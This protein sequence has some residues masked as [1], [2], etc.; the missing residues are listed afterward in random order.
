MMKRALGWML[1]LTVALGV[2]SMTGCS[3]STSTSIPVNPLPVSI[4]TI[5]LPGGSTGSAYSSAI[6]AN[7]GTAPYTF[8]LTSGS[9]PAGLTLSGTGVVMGTP[10]ATG[11]STFVATVT[12]ATGA[13]AS[14]TLSLTIA[15]GS[16]TPVAIV[17]NSLPGGTVGTAYS[18]TVIAANG[19]SPYSF[20][21]TT[22]S[23]P[24]GLTL[25]AG[26]AIT[27]SP[28]TAGS[29]TFTVTVTDAGSKTAS[30]NYTVVV[31]AVGVPVSITTTS[32]VGG[33]VGTAYS[34]SVVA[35]N[36]TSPY[37][38]AVTTGAL[39]AGLSLATSGAITG[40][41]T[42]AGTANFT[43]TVTDAGTKTAIA[44]LSIAIAAAVTPVSISTLT[45]PAGTVG[46]AYSAAI[47]AAN[48]TTPYSFAVTSGALPAGLSL[49]GGTISGSPTTAATS[50]FSVTV[51]DH[52]GGT[53]TQSYSVTI[54][55]AGAPPV[56]TTTTLPG[57]TMGTPYDAIVVASGGTAPYKFSVTS[58][59]LPAG[60][61]L[62]ASGGL[63]GTPTVTGPTTFTISVTDTNGKTAGAN[64]SV[65]IGAAGVGL[66]I[67]PTSLPA[68]T[69]GT[70]YTASLTA[71][72]GSTPYTFSMTGGQLPAGMT[73][74][75]GG[76]L[77]GMPIAAATSYFTVTVVD[78][79]SHVASQNYSVTMNY[80][81]P[82][83]VSITTAILPNAL[84][85]TTYTT[86]VVAT[87]GTAPYTMK[88]IGGALPSG[89]TLASN[90][91]ITGVVTKAATDYFTVQATDSSVP[92][93]TA[94][95]NLSIVSA[96]Y[97]AQVIV[98]PAHVLATVPQGF[99]GLHTS[100]Y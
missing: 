20:A 37:S 32:L 23:L 43:V 18:A 36:G 81:G 21:V 26:G 75:S 27:G 92:A 16:V 98:D 88:V 53:A 58:G 95:A 78:S 17:T 59:T 3:P 69:E 82:P 93:Q 31:G 54:A 56:I 48:G 6:L 42:A 99:F 71:A 87:G 34:A 86:H 67:T 12:D 41:P 8:A 60:V 83:T 70:F 13:K 30:A 10:T 2:L 52:N 1:A 24:A 4:G 77:S 96:S 64:Y 47:V 39:P 51:T 50:T 80:G 45:L 44:N 25:A 22:G 76:V 5:S 100:V 40:T 90:G 85:S 91:T 66:T 35:A 19:T 68:G 61:T 38:F 94:Q 11:T 84:I 7:N 57:G 55:S 33:N 9:L 74:T 73:F 63:T 89:L 28:M 97:S 72:G 79:A 15:S 14:A 62:G 46:S 65:T 49:S 29:S